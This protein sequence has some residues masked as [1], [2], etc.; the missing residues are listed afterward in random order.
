MIYNF[1]KEVVEYFK[2]A[3]WHKKRNV[4][5]TLKIPT[6]E[7]DYPPFI[8]D[9]LYEYGG[10]VVGEEGKGINVAKV[11]INFDPNQAKYQNEE[12]QTF[13]YYSDLIKKQIYPLGIQSDHFYLGI[14]KDGC[15]YN[16]NDYCVYIANSLE[17]GLHDLLTGYC[18]KLIQLDEDTAEWISV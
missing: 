6:K 17:T 11:S 12:D 18:K 2:Q 13:Y 16:L 15:I 1:S 4:K 9:F 7:Y 3:G 5:E 14:D 8:L 10:L